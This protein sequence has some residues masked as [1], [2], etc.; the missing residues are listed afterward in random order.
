MSIL[1][2]NSEGSKLEFCIRGLLKA[3]DVL[4]VF[5]TIYYTFDDSKQEAREKE[6]DVYYNLIRFL[7]GLKYDKQGKGQAIELEDE[8]E[9][10]VDRQ[11]LL[12]DVLKFCSG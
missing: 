9:I 12:P 1:Q 3:S 4:S 10:L 7:E 8:D 2:D 11:V 6:E 5:T